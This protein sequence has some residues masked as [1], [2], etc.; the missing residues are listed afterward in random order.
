MGIW[1]VAAAMVAGYF[2]SMV[3]ISGMHYLLHRRITVSDACE[4]SP[5][6][7]KQAQGSRQPSTI[8]VEQPRVDPSST[9]LVRWQIISLLVRTFLLADFETE[10]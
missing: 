8:A 2:V 10:N 7:G 6:G 1:R 4:S 9:T 3:D 5:Q